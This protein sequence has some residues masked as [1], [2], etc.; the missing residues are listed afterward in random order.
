MLSEKTITRLDIQL[1]VMDENY[2][3]SFDFWRDI[4]LQPPP[5]VKNVTSPAAWAGI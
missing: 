2:F 3:A 5:A 4:V 1:D